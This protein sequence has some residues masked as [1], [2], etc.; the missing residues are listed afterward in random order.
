MSLLILVRHGESEWN[1]SRKITGQADIALT[2]LGKE[3]ARQVGKKLKDTGIDTAYTSELLRAV[4]TLSEIQSQRQEIVPYSKSAALNERD[5]GAFT[6]RIKSDV[7]EEIGADVYARMFQSWDV[8]AP[9]GES[10]EMVYERV[11]PYFKDVILKELQNG[12]NVLVVAH[13]H[14][15]RT[16]VK[17]LEAMSS[18]EVASLKLKNAEA[19]TYDFDPESIVFTKRLVG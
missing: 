5:F 6:G 2:D 10:L 3:Q 8:A 12:K 14:T 1:A 13:H 7:A 4:Q 17:Y 19:I 18:D 11:V 15:L 9:E 16:L